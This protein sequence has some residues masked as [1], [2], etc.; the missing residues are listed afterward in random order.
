VT[1]Y[2]EAAKTAVETV[3]TVVKDVFQVLMGGKSKTA[4][5]QGQALPKGYEAV[6]VEMTGGNTVVK[7]IN[8]KEINKSWPTDDEWKIKVSWTAGLTP[9]YGKDDE[10]EGVSKGD[11]VQNSK[12]TVP[13]FITNALVQV[14]VVSKAGPSSTDIEGKYMD[15]YFDDNGNAI[16]PLHLS[17]DYSWLGSQWWVKTGLYLLKADGSLDV[18]DALA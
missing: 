3:E 8:L 4:D 18:A 10:A 16:L 17:V 7:T 9:H 11:E 12:G 1:E 5:I 13:K 14:S 2:V 6:D 15:A